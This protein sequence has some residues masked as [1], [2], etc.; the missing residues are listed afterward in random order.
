MDRQQGQPLD[1]A[2]TP[3]VPDGSVVELLLAER[4]R[5]CPS[6]GVSNP[7]SDVYCT[8]CGKALP[9]AEDVTLAETLARHAVDVGDVGA[10][11]GAGEGP[12]PAVE[13][14][15]RPAGA[16]VAS[17]VLSQPRDKRPSGRWLVLSGLLL[18]SAIAAAAV[19][20][21]L[22]QSQSRH[23]Q[24]VQAQLEATQ[25]DLASNKATL[26]KTQATLVAARSLAEKRRAVLV[27]TRDVLAKVE[28]LLS[29]V[30][31]IQSNASDVRAQ[32]GTLS[33]DSDLLVG[34]LITLVAYLVGTDTAYV[35]YD[36]VTQLIDEASGELDAVRADQTLLAAD[37]ATYNRAATAF[38]NKADVF[39]ASVRLL[40]KKLRSVTAR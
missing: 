39:S 6:C 20:A 18:M 21:V 38:G 32:A 37:D 2:V 10:A 7:M 9:T 15:D 26:A 24:R 40:E 27:R 28:P 19:F 13:R 8:G 23:V 16:V 5:V 25:N 17:R 3:A 4:I 14:S 11:N 12:P 35:D 34:T 1:A 30:D 31:G 36:Y 33:E 29:S 22:W